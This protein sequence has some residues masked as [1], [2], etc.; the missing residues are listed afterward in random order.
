MFLAILRNLQH[1]LLQAIQNPGERLRRVLLTIRV[2]PVVLLFLVGTG[3]SC[4]QTHV[5]VHLLLALQSLKNLQ[6]RCNQQRHIALPANECG[7][8]TSHNSSR[9][10]I[11]P[12][13]HLTLRSQSITP[14]IR[15]SR[16]TAAVI[17]QSLPVTL[18]TPPCPGVE[19]RSAPLPA[20]PLPAPEGC[21]AS[22]ERSSMRAA[23]A[24]LD[25][26]ACLIRALAHSMTL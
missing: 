21:F 3:Q 2:R 25:R 10:E 5:S 14:P 4:A 20:A 1:L 7:A 16:I 6:Q 12:S 18:T 24:L 8:A 15:K 9:H 17:K 26:G 23:S 19:D 11:T 22:C 13:L